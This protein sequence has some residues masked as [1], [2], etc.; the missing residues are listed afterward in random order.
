MSLGVV[1]FFSNYTFKKRKKRSKEI[2]HL[3]ISLMSLM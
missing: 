3:M 2:T 1:L